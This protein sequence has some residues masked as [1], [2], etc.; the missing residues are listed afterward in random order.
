[1]KWKGQLVKLQHL[2]SRVGNAGFSA[3][4]LAWTGSGRISGVFAGPSHVNMRR[5]VAAQ[6][7]ELSYLPVAARTILDANDRFG[8]E[9]SSERHERCDITD[10]LF[11]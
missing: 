9:Q 2:S 1:M 8:P 5:S 10:R 4:K 3:E 11:L 6:M 7:C